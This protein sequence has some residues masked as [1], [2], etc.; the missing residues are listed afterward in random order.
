MRKGWRITPR[1][2]QRAE[3][4][5]PIDIRPEDDYYYTELESIAHAVTRAS[6]KLTL[7]GASKYD[8][9]ELDAVAREIAQ[10]GGQLVIKG[11]G[12]FNADELESIKRESPNQVSIEQCIAWL[13]SLRAWDAWNFRSRL[14]PELFAACIL[15]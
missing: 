15:N 11:T 8:Y 10:G 5:Q 3:L 2:G 14:F 6:K 7:Q 1:W 9:T 4:G 13:H 12:K